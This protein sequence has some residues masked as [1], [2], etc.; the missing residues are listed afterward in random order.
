MVSADLPAEESPEVS[1][2]GPSPNLWKEEQKVVIER[3]Y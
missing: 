1:Q 3:W 2:L